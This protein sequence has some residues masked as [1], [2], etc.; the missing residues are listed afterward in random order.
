[1]KRS[2]A[3]SSGN[4]ASPASL[5]LTDGHGLLWFIVM[6]RCLAGRAPTDGYLAPSKSDIIFSKTPTNSANSAA[7]LSTEQDMAT[8]FIPPLMQKLTEDKP[9]IDVPGKS[10]REVINNLEEMYPGTRARLVDGF[11]IKPNISIAVDG[12]VTP[13][14]ML[15]KVQDSSEVHFL[16]AIG[17]G[18]ATPGLGSSA[19]Q[20]YV[21]TTTLDEVFS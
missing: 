18:L 8:V 2:G 7:D 3:E 6:P 12:Q 10:V 20:P 9:T 5:S 4:V 1:M 19:Q 16:P 17:G 13:L 15:E 14:G 11:K 21:P